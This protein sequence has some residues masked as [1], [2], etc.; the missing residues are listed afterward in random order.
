MEA[1]EKHHVK[2]EHMKMET[3]AL[4]VGGRALGA[5]NFAAAAKHVCSAVLK[6][7]QLFPDHQSADAHPASLLEMAE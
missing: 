7:R 1:R 4:T 6:V 5:R 2:A 3:I